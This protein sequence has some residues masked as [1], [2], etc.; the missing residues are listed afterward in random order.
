MTQQQEVTAYA[1]ENNGVGNLDDNWQIEVENG[2][3]WTAGTKIRLIHSRTK[4]ALHSHPYGSKEYTS[5]QQEVTGFDKRNA[6][7][8]WLAEIVASTE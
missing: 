1:P 2:G 8:F 4:V 5:D 7:D 6:D 3:V